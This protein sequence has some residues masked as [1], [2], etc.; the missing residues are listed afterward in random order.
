MSPKIGS[1]IE[2]DGE[3]KGRKFRGYYSNRVAFVKI[4]TLWTYAEW[5]PHHQNWIAG[6]AYARSP[7]A[8]VE[9]SARDNLATARS[10]RTLIDEQLHGELFDE[11]G[12]EI[13]IDHLTGELE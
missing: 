1:V 4:G 12:N 11:N 13:H 5:N 7:A 9:Y 3:Y 6:N 8:A 2:C 10:I